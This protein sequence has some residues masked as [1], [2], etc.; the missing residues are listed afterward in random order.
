MKKPV[1]GV[2]PLWDDEKNSVW[3]LPAYLEGLQEAGALPVVFPID[4]TEDD[5]QQLYELCD[6]FLFTGGHDIDPKY[7]GQEMTEL[8]GAPCVRRDTLEAGIFQR[9]FAGKKPMLG[10]CRGSQAFNVFLG[11]TLYQDL[12]SQ[13]PDVLAH[14]MTPP[15]NQVI[16]T[17]KLME[18]GLM[19]RLLQKDELGVNSFHHQGICDL[20]PALRAEAVSA[21]G[22]I[23]A[24]SCPEHP[25]L[26]AVQ[27]HPE[28]LQRDDSHPGILFR[29]FVDSC[30]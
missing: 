1:I 7:Y 27:W 6:G 28:Y 20:A 25:F 15:Y 14:R 8:C 10:I 22:L 24:V 18:N 29:A 21:D 5:M 9:A 19:H 11:G 26:L 17:V 3:M 12:P 13:K 30:K 4:A 2:I 16:H 23:E